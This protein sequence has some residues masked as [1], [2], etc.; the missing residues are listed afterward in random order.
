MCKVSKPSVKTVQKH[1]LFVN[2]QGMLMEE[3][4]GNLQT[5]DDQPSKKYG[6][7]IKEY[8][9]LIQS[10]AQES[11]MY[12]N[13]WLMSDDYS[14]NLYAQ[15]KKEQLKAIAAYIQATRTYLQRISRRYNI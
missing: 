3:F 9:K 15:A 6:A 8:G 14:I 11:L 2:K 7:A 5:N 4:G 12:V 13:L 1:T 10:Y